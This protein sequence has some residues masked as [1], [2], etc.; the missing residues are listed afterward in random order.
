MKRN[1]VL[2]SLSLV[3]LFLPGPGR[4]DDEPSFVRTE[5][6]VYGRKFGTALTMDIFTP[7]KDANGLGV[8]LVV[9]GGWFSAHSGISLPFVE[10]L[11]GRGYTVFAVVHGSQPRF[12]IPE[13]LQD[14]NR[15]VR[16]VRTHAR[17]YKIDPE[18]IGIY[19]ASAG[20]HLSLMQGPRATEETGSPGTRV[21]AVIEPRPGGRLLLPADGLPELRQAGGGRHRARH[22]RRVQA[23]V[24]L[25][26]TGREDGDLRA[27]HGRGEDPRDR[28]ANLADHA[29]QRRRPAR[30]DH[31]R[32]R[33][34]TS[35]CPSSRPPRRSTC[36]K[37]KEVGVEVEAGGQAPAAGHGW[38]DLPKDIGLLADWFDDHL[39]KNGWS[40]DP[41]SDHEVGVRRPTAADRVAT[42]GLDLPINPG[43]GAGRTSALRRGPAAYQ[44]SEFLGRPLDRR[45]GEAN[46]IMPRPEPAGANPG[47]TGTG[48]QGG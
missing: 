6:I 37:F 7:R 24:R 26:G 16:F 41:E 29:R 40:V 8:V 46:P 22:T 18:R 33:R 13:I 36:A 4:A 15:A 9:S 10:P 5:D 42:R 14:M 48:C 3:I 12:T 21:E 11:V 20:G 28:S 34:R 45:R 32:G 39:K 35:S 17:D 38:P 47:G 31:P 27:G 44:A 43:Q 2:A 30:P 25:P 19:G 1:P 23:S